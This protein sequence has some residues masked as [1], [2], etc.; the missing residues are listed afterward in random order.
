MLARAGRQQAMLMEILAGLEGSALA[1]GLRGSKWVYPLVNAGHIAGIALLFGAIAGFDLRLMG[2]W[3]RVPLETLA[4][5]WFPSPAR[6]SASPRL[7]QSA[8]HRQGHR[9]RRLVPVPGKD[10]LAGHRPCQS[11]RLPSAVPPPRLADGGGAALARCRDARVARYRSASGCPCSF[12]AGS[13]DTFKARMGQPEGIRPPIGAK[14]Q[15]FAVRKSGPS[16]R[17]I[18][19][20]MYYGRWDVV[21]ARRARAR[22]MPLQERARRADAKGSQILP[23]EARGR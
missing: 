5:S 10:G 8:L 19:S 2:A 11:A 1:A 12:S 21:P 20:G 3:P 16:A 18:A 14:S 6:A 9:I 7:R 4:K 15:R 23:K 17:A 22:I 13:S